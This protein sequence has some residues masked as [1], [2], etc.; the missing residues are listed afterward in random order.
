MKRRSKAA[1]YIKWI[2]A[3]LGSLTVLF[4]VYFI[5]I[6]SLKTAQEASSLNFELPEV[7][8][9]DNYLRV[10]EE[11]NLIRAF[12]NSMLMA[13]GSVFICL[14]VSA[15]TAFVINRNKSGLN[16]V[17]NNYY[18]LGLIAP[19]N[20]VAT[21]FVLK[22]LHIQNTYLGAILVFAAVGIP[23]MVFLFSSFIGGIPK[24]LDEAAIIDGSGSGQLFFRIIFPL[25]KPVI[26]TGLVLNFLGSWNDFVTPLYLLDDM[27]KLGMINSIYNF[28]GLY[29]ND[30]N[31]IFANILLSVAPIMVLYILG[32]KY[33]VSG[34]TSGALKG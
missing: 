13:G 7:F 4:P 19:V 2:A 29:F 16:K 1:D 5:V 24:E 18:F 25:L 3:G 9:W 30:W 17:L 28:F 21:I 15:M 10:I 27:D 12:G 6:N 31:M 23:F 22:F 8:Q 14:L 32:Q 26:V 34:T 33:I 11:G 20:Y